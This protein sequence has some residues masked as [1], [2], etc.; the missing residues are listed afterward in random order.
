MPRGHDLLR[1]DRDLAGLD[2]DAHVDDPL[3]KRTAT[4]GRVH[5][6]VESR[7]STNAGP[8]RAARHARRAVHARLQR[9]ARLLERSREHRAGDRR[10]P[11]H[12]HRRHRGDGRRRLRQ[13]RGRIKDM[14]IRGG[15]NIY[16]REIEEFLY[17]HPAIKDVQVIGVPDVKYGEELCAWVVLQRGDRALGGRRQ[18]VLL[19]QDRAL[20]NSAL[21]AVRRRV[22]DDGNRQGA[23]V[24]DARDVD[25]GTRAAVGCGRRHGVAPKRRG[26]RLSTPA[27]GR[28]RRRTLSQRLAPCS[29]GARGPSA[30]E[31][32]AS[33][34]ALSGFEQLSAAYSPPTVEVIAKYSSALRRLFF[35]TIIP[36]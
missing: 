35:G 20:Q 30:D 17:A 16:P 18:G 19:R 6:H 31:M 7:S 26:R 29:L 15:E 22:S 33:A 13:H 27:V 3:E 34:L 1:H 32:I 36:A 14:V 28:E 23:E 25:R 9:D 5:P 2:S 12:A 8:H 4:V 21:R 24:Q 10:R 11:L